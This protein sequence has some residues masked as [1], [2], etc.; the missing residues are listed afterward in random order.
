MALSTTRRPVSGT[1]HP[2]RRVTRAATTRRLAT[3]GAAAGPLFVLVTAG[4]L[5]GHDDFDL[6]HQP[7]SLLALGPAGWIQVLNF[8]LPGL[9]SLF[10]AAAV[11][12]AWSGGPGRTWVPLLLTVFGSGLVA[13]GVF[14]PDPALGYPPGTPDRIPP[15]ADFSWH[16]WVHSVTPPAA[17]SALIAACLVAVRRFRRTGQRPWAIGSLVTALVC[18]AL[19][20]WPSPATAST[21]LVLATVVGF[22]WTTAL[23]M[24]LRRLAPRSADTGTNSRP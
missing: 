1:R 5:L 11:R 6:T 17:F 14:L 22:C 15:A 21:R 4:Q 9:L 7:L 16:G 19:V 24:S 3:A 13:A 18:V 23:G 2:G 10:L 20:A 8:V 12:N